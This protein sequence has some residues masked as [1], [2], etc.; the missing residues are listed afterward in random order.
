MWTPNVTLYSLPTT[1]NPAV[2]SD[3]SRNVWKFW[4]NLL[5]LEA[6]NV[7]GESPYELEP[8]SG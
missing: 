1:M 6:R 3:N 5:A 7:P 4:V 2:F 8:L